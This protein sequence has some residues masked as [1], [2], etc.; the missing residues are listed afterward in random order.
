MPSKILQTIIKPFTAKI[1]KPWDRVCLIVLLSTPVYALLVGL[2]VFV[3]NFVS[4]NYLYSFDIG[5][6]EFAILPFATLVILLIHH[7]LSKTK[8]AS[9][10]IRWSVTLIFLEAVAYIWFKAWVVEYLFTNEGGVGYVLTVSDR[11]EMILTYVKALFQT[12]VIVLIL[13]V[14]WLFKKP[15]QN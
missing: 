8:S 4:E 6:I 15:K 9:R 14:G 12:V 2:Y 10:L 11:L 3:Y 5:L 1:P 13:I 7:S